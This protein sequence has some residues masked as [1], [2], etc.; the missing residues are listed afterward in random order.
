MIADAVTVSWKMICAS[1]LG[2]A[3]PEAALLYLYVQAGN[4]PSLAEGARF[5]K[6]RA[7]F[8]RRC[9]PCGSWAWGLWPSGEQAGE[10]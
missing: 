7:G 6:R 5:F 8:L 4:D 3:S 10:M 1:S 9:H 2:A